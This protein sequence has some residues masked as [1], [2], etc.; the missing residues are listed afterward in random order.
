M[1]D[2]H[3][4]VMPSPFGGQAHLLNGCAFLSAQGFVSGQII[5]KKE[6]VVIALSLIEHVCVCFF[7]VEDNP[8][9]E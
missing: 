7:S 3:L 5:H 6:F 9:Y 8:V 4:S 2:S 1:L